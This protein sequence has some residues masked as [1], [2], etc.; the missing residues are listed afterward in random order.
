MIEDRPDA[1]PLLLVA[2]GEATLLRSR[3]PLRR[4]TVTRVKSV[5]KRLGVVTVGVEGGAVR[6]YHRPSK[7]VPHL[8]AALKADTLDAESAFPALVSGGVSPAI[9]SK[10]DAGEAGKKE[11]ALHGWLESVETGSI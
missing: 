11:E 7:P 9:L 3:R 1:A 2:M 6:L 8:C 4:A 5:A 10:R